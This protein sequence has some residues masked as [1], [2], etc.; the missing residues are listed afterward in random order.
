M[1]MLFVAVAEPAM[2]LYVC[3]SKPRAVG[4]FFLF[5][6]LTSGLRIPQES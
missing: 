3:R 6:S 2:Y 4:S 1:T 5:V